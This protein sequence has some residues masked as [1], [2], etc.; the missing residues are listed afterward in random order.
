[1]TKRKVLGIDLGTT[2]SCVAYVNDYGAAEVLAN[3]DNERTTPSVVWFDGDHVVVG[4][5]AKEMSSVYPN[6][7][8]SFIKRQMGNDDF[9][10][11][12]DGYQY[13]PEHISSL[14][15][16]K[17]VQDAWDRLGEEVR[18]VVITCPAYFFIRERDATMLAGTEAGLNV[19]QIVNEPTAA[20][21][22]Y[23]IQPGQANAHGNVLVYDL[24]G[25][26][27]DVT[28]IKVSPG[29]LDV[30]CTDGDHQLGGKDWDDRLAR[31]LAEKFVDETSIPV[32]L[33]EDPEF[34]YDLMEQ[35]EK[36]KKHL[37]QKESVS[38]KFSHEGEKVRIEVTRD[39]FEEMTRDLLE[40]S[41][42]FVDS[43]LKVA[44]EKGIT[45]IDQVI[46]VGGSSRMPQ[47][48]SRMGKKFDVPPSLFDPDE[49]VAKGAAII[50]NNLVLKEKL[51]E[52]LQRGDRSRSLVFD[53]FSES[54]KRAAVE[55]VA[56]ETGYSTA[57]VSG[58]L[59]NIR[60][61]SSKTFG[62]VALETDTNIEKVSNM[63]YRNTPIP[64]EYT[65]LFFTVVKNQ[66]SV[67][68]E[69]M[70]NMSDAPQNYEQIRHDFK[71]YNAL[72]VKMNNNPRSL[73][74]EEMQFIQQDNANVITKKAQVLS[75]P[76]S[77]SHKLWEGELD[78]ASG[79]PAV[80]PIEA[81][82]KLDDSGL[83]TI[84][85]EDCASGNRIIQSIQTGVMQRNDD[86]KKTT[87][88][89]RGLTVD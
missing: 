50:G 34:Y 24:G 89:C 11:D 8:C 81:T 15:L 75:T 72:C 36:A 19:L 64:C 18:D 53:D 20:A 48:A 22:S 84:I 47:V 35:A 56:E 85:V 9:T 58:A 26:T 49:A 1:M 63:I 70:E 39:E 32:D 54:E 76:I 82:Y 71:R 5:A 6:A 42:N 80:S 65:T 44:R 59:R 41:I 21:V 31:F 79:L 86:F 38:V 62:F 68:V 13:T 61:V 23:G 17:L 27:F 83:L 77:E 33:A 10:F 30:V 16:R 7:V 28:I 87:G 69:L 45:H 88:H 74:N 60:N 55:K 25:G 2:Y 4:Q 14:I 51:S 12:V 40:K 67:L 52:K 46:L 73:S 3:R 66:I 37:S 57:V 43:C 78:L 29:G